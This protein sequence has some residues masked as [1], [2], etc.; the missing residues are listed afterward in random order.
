VLQQL[1]MIYIVT[2]ATVGTFCLCFRSYAWLFAA[3][4]NNGNRLLMISVVTSY[5]R[6]RSKTQVDR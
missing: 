3:L 5:L 1:K 6:A 2:R 4:Y